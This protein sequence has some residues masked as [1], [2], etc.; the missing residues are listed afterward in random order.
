MPVLR[1]AEHDPLTGLYNRGV[2]EEELEKQRR[3]RAC[4]FLVDVD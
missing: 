4:L 3:R 2:Y 1:E